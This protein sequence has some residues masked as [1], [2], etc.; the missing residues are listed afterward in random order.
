M[1]LKRLYGKI[2]KIEEKAD[3]TLLV[4][5]VASTEAVDDQGEVVKA[6]AMRRA[7]P[8]YLREDGTGPIRE[9]HERWAAGKT[10]G[11]QVDKDNVTRM[12][13]HVVDSEACKKVKEKV[14]QGFSIGGDVPLGGRNKE[15]PKIIE[16]L[17]LV[18]I[19]LVD[20]PANPEATFKVLKIADTDAAEK[21]KVAKDDDVDD[22]AGE[23]PGEQEYGDVSFADEKNKKYPIDTEEHI[24]AA[25]NYINKPKNA[26]KYSASELASVKAKIVAAWKKTIDKD[27]PPSAAK[28]KAAEPGAVKKSMYQIQWAAA[29]CDELMSLAQSTQWEADYEGD[30][31]GIPARLKQLCSQFAEIFKDLVAEETDELVAM[32]GTEAIALLAASGT[33]KKSERAAVLARALIAGA[34]RKAPEL[35]ELVELRKRVEESESATKQ[36]GDAL[37]KVT[38]E[39]NELHAKFSEATLALKAKGVAKDPRF[40]ESVAKVDALE[41]ALAEAQA[42]TEQ[43]GEALRKTMVERDDLKKAKEQLEA[44]LDVTTRKA[45]EQLDGVIEERNALT[46]QR[47][48]AIGE[49]AVAKVKLETKGVL[50]TVAVDKARDGVDALVRDEAKPAEGTPERALWELKKV[51][52]GG[53]QPLAFAVLPPPAEE[54]R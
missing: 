30:G 11:I 16:Q 44:A 53:G 50:K 38:A 14:Y 31:S 32:K 6:D 51:Q 33:L 7:I 26:D 41:T 3:G 9:M 42:A 29:L 34:G 24:R 27:G 12:V 23:K 54:R 2:E 4:E 15:N 36:A 40:V 46:A 25:W 47:D 13:A 49:L 43:A 35:P 5:G 39:R 37:Q 45:K 1:S 19:S 20:R 17:R 21:A 28:E 18:E 8:D 48:T 22:A 52:R 10:V